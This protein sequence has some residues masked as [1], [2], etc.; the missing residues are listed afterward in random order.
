M[1]AVFPS[2]KTRFSAKIYRNKRKRRLSPCKN[3]KNAK[4]NVTIQK[5]P[6]EDFVAHPVLLLRAA[7]AGADRE[8]GRFRVSERSYGPGRSG[9][10][11]RCPEPLGSGGDPGGE[12]TDDQ[13]YELPGPEGG[14]FR[15][16]DFQHAGGTGT[17]L[18]H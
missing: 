18:R 16:A 1:L 8:G 17:A 14:L 7:D 9:K 6:A 10:Q 4:N 5:F 2:K 3:K 11:Y 15:Q 12:R 13:R